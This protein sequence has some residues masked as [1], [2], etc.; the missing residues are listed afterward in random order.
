MLIC[1]LYSSVCPAGNTTIFHFVSSISN[2]DDATGLP[3]LLSFI[4]FSKFSTTKTCVVTG[5]SLVTELRQDQLSQSSRLNLDIVVRVN[6]EF[7]NLI[8]C[9][10]ESSYYRL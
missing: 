4:T 3:T 6:R 1:S 7:G 2:W 9:R 10:S 5:L 8:S